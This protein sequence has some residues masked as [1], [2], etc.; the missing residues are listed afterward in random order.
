[1]TKKCI[2][3]ILTI[4]ILWAISICETYSQIKPSGWDTYSIPDVCS[5]AIPST[6]EVRSDD[7]FH[8]R[9]VKTMRQGSFFEMLCDNCDLFYDEATLVLQPK[10]LNSNP[11]SASFQQ[12]NDSYARI[13][14][15]FSYDELTQEDVK[16]LTPSDLKELNQ[17]IYEDAKREFDCIADIIPT[18]GQLKWYPLCK[19]Y[20]SGFQ[21]LVEEYDRPAIEGGL[22]HVKIYMFFYDKKFLKVT[23]SYKIKEESKY[24]NDFEKFIQLLSIE[25]EKQHTQQTTCSGSGLFTSTEYRFK[26]AYDKTQYT[27]TPKQ[28]KSSHCFCK[29]ESNTGNNIIIFSAWDIADEDTEGSVYEEDFISGVRRMDNSY[30]SNNARLLSSCQKVKIGGKD[31]LKSVFSFDVLGIKYIQTTYRVY[32][33]GRLYTLDFHIPETDYNNNKSITDKLVKGVQFN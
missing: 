26:Y 19:K 29:L 27:V 25:T 31:A 13:M 33:K 30:N 17:V 2:Y 28:N 1:M 16:E 7:S 6:M 15:D 5:F 8:G 22:T 12:A 20:I 10:G 3:K 32:H 4:I 11:Y 24:K 9:F 18:S 14:F 23:T 21:T